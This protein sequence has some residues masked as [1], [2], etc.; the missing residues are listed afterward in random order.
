MRIRV[1][2][3][4]SLLLSL[5]ISAATF[6]ATGLAHAGSHLTGESSKIVTIKMRDFKAGLRA[7]IQGG[8]DV[9]G[10]NVTEG[11]VDVVIANSSLKEVVSLKVGSV[12]KA[13]DIDPGIAPDTQYTSFDE[14]TAKINDFATRY[15]SLVTVESIG[16][17]HENRDIWAVKITSDVL[18]NER[19]PAIFFNAMHHAREVM[20]TEVALD[21]IERLTLGYESDEMVKHWVDTNQIWIVP[22]VNP[23]G[24]NKV[25]TSNNMWRKNV[26]EG[27]GVDINRNYPYA[28]G[29]CN[30][31]SGSTWSDTYRGPSAGSEPE[32]RA[33]MGLVSRIEPVLSISYHSYSELV[34]YP[35]GCD[36]A[37]T[38]ERQVV[39]SVGQTLASKMP[40]DGSSG[41][42]DPGTSWELLYAVDGGDIDWYYHEH[43]VLPY[44]I[45]VN[46]SNQGFQPAYSWRKPT[47]EKLRAAWGY[48]LDRAEQSGIRG[49]VKGLNSADA[50]GTVTIT[51]MGRNG[52]NLEPRIYNIKKDGTF[53][54]VVEPGM[55]NVSVDSGGRSASLDV[56]V[57]A[58]RSDLEVAL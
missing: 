37:H 30:G 31:S 52:E 23:D 25:W 34:I 47:V 22:M 54:V 49:V 11:T 27:Y 53:H 17:S 29:T 56:T 48:M 45:E 6:S 44:V 39:E 7:L 40:K 21:M 9:A 32:T 55:Y 13:R 36:G 57:G 19:K 28:W 2:S 1:N 10:V 38:P 16:K 8:Y 46:S 58:R 20:T 51:P 3:I 43:H 12:V 35:Y 15:P 18:P 42:Y 33:M 5:T 14:L 50:A 4:T 26:R 24:N 41:T